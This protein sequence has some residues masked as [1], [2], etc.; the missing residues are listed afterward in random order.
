MR[1]LVRQRP[2]PPAPAPEPVYSQD[3]QRERRRKWLRVHYRGDFDL[4]GEVAAIV[5]PLA[6]QVAALPG[7]LV[8]RAEVHEV[9]DATHELVS[10]IVGMLAESK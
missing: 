8:L 1:S 9:S 3:Q 7:P 10:T 5:D 6:A 2:Q 4:A